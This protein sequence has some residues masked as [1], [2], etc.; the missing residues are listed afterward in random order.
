MSNKVGT[1]ASREEEIAFLCLE[2]ILG[3]EIFLAD[4]GSGNAQPDGCWKLSDA[5]DS[6]AYVEITSPE[7]SKKMRE[8]N[9]QWKKVRAGES[10]RVTDDGV[11]E[12]TGLSAAE[13]ISA[14]L[15]EQWAEGNIKK[16]KAKEAEEC[17]LYL[18]GRTIAQD[19]TFEDFR[20]L[21]YESTRIELPDGITDLWLEGLCVSAEKSERGVE[22]FIVRILH[23]NRYDGCSAHEVLIREEQLPAPKRTQCDLPRKRNPKQRKPSA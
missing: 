12:F 1:Q 5:P 10:T 20:S 6:W 22:S 21:M 17:H 18:I 2:K 13:Q 14:M 4:S 8:L 3:V 16:L 11:I 19:L 23:L 9:E 7:C 15:R